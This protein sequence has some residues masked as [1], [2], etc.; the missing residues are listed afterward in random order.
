MHIG[1]K[2]T[3]KPD[4][5]RNFPKFAKQQEWIIFLVEN[6]NYIVYTALT[7]A[8]TLINVLDLRLSFK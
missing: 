1:L 8:E 7:R 3:L 2:I 5:K 4:Y 6:A